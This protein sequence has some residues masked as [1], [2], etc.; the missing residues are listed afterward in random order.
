MVREYELMN[1]DISMLRFAC[2]RNAFDEP[3][4]TEIEWRTE[5]RSIGYGNLGDFLAHRQAPKHRKHIKELLERYGCDDLEG[6]LR[7]THA[8]SL[9]DTFWVKEAGSALCWGSVS[10]YQ[11]EFDQHV[12]VAAIDGVISETA[13]SS[14]SPEFTTDGTYAKCWVRDA[15][16]IWLYKSGSGLHVIEPTSEFL[17]SQLAEKICPNADKIIKTDYILQ[18]S[19]H[20]LI[21]QF[22]FYHR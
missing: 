19:F 20:E 21:L 4:F 22:P 7:E 6:F 10:L 16:G 18:K 11:N 17:V 9:N 13:L 2:E 5:L 15:N 8:L 1:K 12:S 14:T 3:E